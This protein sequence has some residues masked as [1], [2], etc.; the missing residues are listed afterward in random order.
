[1][2]TFVN[3]LEYQNARMMHDANHAAT[4]QYCKDNKTNCIPCAISA[5]FP[6]SNEV[7][8]ELRT[9]IEVWEFIHEKPNKY[10]VY[11]NETTRKATTWTGEVLGNVFFGTEY[12]S[13]MGD[14]RQ[15]ID[16][17]GINGIKYYG[18]FFKSA[19]DYAMINAKKKQN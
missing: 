16:V 12:R 19:G 3:E 10:M 11:V 7:N 14:K 1:M 5:T 6:Y 4:K 15:P 18:T 13:N 8:N 9:K 17:I 2:N